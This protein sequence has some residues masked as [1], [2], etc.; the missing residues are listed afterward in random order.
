M[1]PFLYTALCG[2]TAFHIAKRQRRN[3]YFWGALGCVLKMYAFLILLVIIPF[4]SILLGVIIRKKLRAQGSFTRKA[5]ADD[6]V[7]CLSELDASVLHKVWYYLDSNNQTQ[8]PISGQLL[9]KKWKEGTILAGTY[10]WN[11]TLSEWKTVMEVFPQ[12]GYK[13]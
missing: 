9:L 1:W 5:P 8:G 3:P 11:E 13:K 2:I 10:I 4:L 7:I 6:N 12:G